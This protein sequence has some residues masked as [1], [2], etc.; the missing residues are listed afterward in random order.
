ML[1]SV[2]FI[3]IECLVL[4]VFLFGDIGFDH[5]GRFGLDFD[6]AIML[7]V[8][9]C[10][11][12]L[13]GVIY[14]ARNRRWWAIALQLVIPVVFYL[15]VS[16]PPRVG[17]PLNPANYQHLVGKTKSEVEE[18][19]TGTRRIT[20]GFLHDEKGEREFESYNGMRIFYSMDG[21]VLSVET[22]E[23]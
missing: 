23:W 20:S 7:A 12:L 14:T 3:A 4:A 5:P 6:D 18:A 15:Y 22:P 8:L 9:Y 19:L 11:V 16:A 17:P 10:G 13:G 1:G 2:I 21:H